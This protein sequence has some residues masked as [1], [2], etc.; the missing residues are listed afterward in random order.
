MAD[1]NTTR[2][3][4]SILSAQIQDMERITPGV[5]HMSSEDSVYRGFFIPK[6]LF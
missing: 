6:G 2:F 1:G 5:P 4:Y 3:D